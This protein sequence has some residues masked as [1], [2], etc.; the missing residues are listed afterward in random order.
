MGTDRRGSLSEYLLEK[1]LVVDSCDGNDCL[2]NVSVLVGIATCF[3]L[4]GTIAVCSV[5]LETLSALLVFGET[6]RQAGKQA[7]R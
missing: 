5:L 2:R 4:Q 1:V 3:T 7:E 6:G